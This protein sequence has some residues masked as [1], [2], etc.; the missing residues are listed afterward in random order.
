MKVKI[1]GLVS[2]FLLILSSCTTVTLVPSYNADIEKE[3]ILTQKLNEKMYLDL[4]SLPEEQRKFKDFEKKYLEIESNINSIDFQTKTREKNKDFVAMISVLKKK[5]T[6]YKEYHKS[7]E[8]LNKG[9]IETYIDNIN[10]FYLPILLAEN[11][12]KDQ[13]K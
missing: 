13:I 1:L 4:L 7:K 3:I 10:A 5:F 12:L 8:I 6:E 2:V 9:E 11:V